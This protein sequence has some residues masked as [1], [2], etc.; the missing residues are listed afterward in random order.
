M[1]AELSPHWDS[2]LGVIRCQEGHAWPCHFYAWASSGS[3]RCVHDG[4]PLEW[5]AAKRAHGR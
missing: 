4:S 3:R 5:E 1:T 2:P